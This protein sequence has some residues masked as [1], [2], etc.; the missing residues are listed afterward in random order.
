MEARLD[1]HELGLA[2]V[3]LGEAHGALVGFGAGVAEEGLLEV[4]GGD[5]GELLGQGADGRHVVDVAAGVDELVGL[6]LGGLDDGRVVVAGVGD[7]DAGEAVDVLFAVDVVEPGA[8]AVV[9]HDRLDAFDEAGHD[10]VAILV[11]DTHAIDHPSS[12]VFLAGCCAWIGAAPGWGRA[13]TEP[14]VRAI[15]PAPGRVAARP[16]TGR[17]HHPARPRSTSCPVG[18]AA[19]CDEPTNDA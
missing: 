1:G 2:G 10:V 6:R 9:D 12:D 18:C 11:L 7:R 14:G 19:D 15:L 5:L 13:W 4:A 17:I 16:S 8:L 3:A